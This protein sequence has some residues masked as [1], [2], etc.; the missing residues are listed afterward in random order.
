MTKYYNINNGRIIIKPLA[1]MAPIGWAM[2]AFFLLMPVTIILILV[3]GHIQEIESKYFG[4][5]ILMLP[6]LLACIPLFTYSRRQVI[7]DGNQ[8]IVYLKTIFGQKVLMTFANVAGIVCKVTF[9]QVY[10]INS[11]DDRYGKGYR[12]SPSFAKEKDKDKLYYESNVLPEIWKMIEMAP[13]SPVADN[14][15]AL[16]DAGN[17]S[18][19]KTVPTGFLLKP[20]SILKFLPLL[21]LAGPAIFYYWYQ[22]FTK[23]AATN[24]DK[25]VSF[26]LLIP[27]VLSLLTVTKRVVFDTVQ[28]KVKVYRLGFVFVTYPITEMAGFNIVRKTYNGLY[29]GTDVRLKFVKPGSKT[30]RELTLQ[31]FNKTNP[32]EPFIN[33]T[34]FVIAQTDGGQRK[35]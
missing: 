24:S 4:Y 25:Q 9:G 19:Y 21:I 16:L 15:K 22:T 11:K 17:L 32:V 1:F 18:Y 23:I 20:A 26:F 12:I 29:S 30:P 33:E 7:F 35:S 13:A 5:Y 8:Q 10:F 31:D 14:S 2:V 6:F 3:K 27:I 28:R 34:E